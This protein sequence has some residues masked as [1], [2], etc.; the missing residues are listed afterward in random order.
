MD[1]LRT[2]F[3]AIIDNKKKVE[4]IKSLFKRI[5]Q[6]VLIEVKEMI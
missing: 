4:E 3:N 2:N 6:V 1:G 5:P